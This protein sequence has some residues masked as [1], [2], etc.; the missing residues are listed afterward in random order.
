[1]SVLRDSRAETNEQKS[2]WHGPCEQRKLEILAL[3]R[4]GCQRRGTSETRLE[5]AGVAA[6]DGPLLTHH[7]PIRILSFCQHDC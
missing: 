7:R 5:E 3:A 2:R 4:G 6:S 1:M